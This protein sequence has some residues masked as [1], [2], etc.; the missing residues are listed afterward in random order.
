MIDIRKFYGETRIEEADFE[1]ES[2]NPEIGLKY[3]KTEIL[4]S[5]SNKKKYGIE[6][7]KEEIN[8][9]NKTKEKGSAYGI[10]NSE[11]LIEN[12]LKIFIQNKVTPIAINDILNDFRKNPELVLVNK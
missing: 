10:S 5:N 7:V 3:Y 2:N 12:I 9:K 6:I 1:G 8:G 11:E 4:L